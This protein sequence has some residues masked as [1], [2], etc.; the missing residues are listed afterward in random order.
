[1]KK[2]LLSFM[3]LFTTS[4]FAE[5]IV[6]NEQIDELHQ[7]L[8]TH[9][10]D[11][12]FKNSTKE[13]V[14]FGEIEEYNNFMKENFKGIQLKVAEGA[15]MGLQ[16]SGKAISANLGSATASNIGV[17]MGI[18]LVVGLV[19]API[20]KAAQKD[21]E[22]ILIYDYTDIKNIKSRVAIMFVADGFDD[23]DKIRNYL[24]RYLVQ[25]GY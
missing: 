8:L 20:V 2:S 7:V 6:E 13:L 18:G 16:A 21:N 12:N 14:F 11:I 25:K 4:L 19:L 10:V 17:G 23:E 22:M 5:F 9:T 24:D 3:F 15:L 1:M